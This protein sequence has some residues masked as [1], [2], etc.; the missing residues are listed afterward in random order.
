MPTPSRHCHE[1]QHQQLTTRTAI[2]EDS[3]WNDPCCARG[4]PVI[5]VAFAAARSAVMQHAQCHPA[6]GYCAGV[7]TAA[8]GAGA[9]VTRLRHGERAMLDAA[10]TR[11]HTGIPNTHGKAA[12]HACCCMQAAIAG[13][14]RSKRRAA[15][16]PLTTRQPSPIKTIVNKASHRQPPRRHVHAIP[17]ALPALQPQPRCSACKDLQTPSLLARLF[18]CC[19]VLC[20]GQSDKLFRRCS[21]SAATT[22]RARQT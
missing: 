7:E 10:C 13:E 3:S 16:P 14:R 15:I 20:G 9:D 4:P 2:A 12:A 18:E 11:Q 19:C 1:P 17:F 8:A 22:A 6:P 5:C 21:A